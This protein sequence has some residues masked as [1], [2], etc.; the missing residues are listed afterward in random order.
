MSPPTPL[1]IANSLRRA[2]T[3][4]DIVTAILKDI[5]FRYE[6]YYFDEGWEFTAT[7]HDD[8]W[9]VFVVNP[10]LPEAGFYVYVGRN[11]G[12]VY[13]DFDELATKPETAIEIARTLLHGRFLPLRELGYDDLWSF[14]ATEKDNKWLVFV[15]PAEEEGY[16]VMGAEFYVY[17]QRSD[18]K[19]LGFYRG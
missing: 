3:A 8:R 15:E 1:G 12:K 16:M 19:I 11:D 18:A 2:E 14:T 9:V 4:I 10:E 17:I 13:H 5:D 6:E 7:E